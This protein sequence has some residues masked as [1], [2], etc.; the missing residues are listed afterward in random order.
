MDLINKKSSRKSKCQLVIFSSIRRIHWKNN[1][2]KSKN[3][4]LHY[5]L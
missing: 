3:Y 5:N 1:D 4:K 2:W